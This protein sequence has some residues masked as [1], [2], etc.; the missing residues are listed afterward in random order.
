MVTSIKNKIQEQKT[1]RPSLLLII[2]PESLE[3][4]HVYI[5]VKVFKNGTSKIFSGSI[6]EYLGPYVVQKKFTIYSVITTIQFGVKISSIEF[7]RQFHF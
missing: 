7:L 6:L 4:L 2:A 3:Q 5:W 1:F